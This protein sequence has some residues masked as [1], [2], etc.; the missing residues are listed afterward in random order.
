MAKGTYESKGFVELVARLQSLK[1]DAFA[2]KIVKDSMMKASLVIRDAAKREAPKVSGRLEL[3]IGRT[4]G[5]DAEGMFV[6]RVGLIKFGGKFG[7]SQ[8]SRFGR[9]KRGEHRLGVQLTKDAWYGRI[10][11]NGSKYQKANPFL[12][13]AFVANKEGYTTKLAEILRERLDKVAR[14]TA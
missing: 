3:F 7:K 4:V 11:H 1:D 5:K 2:D 8:L 6:C 9:L 12:L 10:V 14:K 13:R